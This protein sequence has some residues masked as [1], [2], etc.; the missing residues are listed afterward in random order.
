MR[1]WMRDA[2]VLGSGGE[3]WSLISAGLKSPGLA[4]TPVL[5]FAIRSDSTRVRRS[6]HVSR[7]LAVTRNGTG[8]A[9]SPSPSAHSVRSSVAILVDDRKLYARDKS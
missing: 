4:M 2:E 7:A 8:A 6:L 3:A 9:A 5:D 1:C